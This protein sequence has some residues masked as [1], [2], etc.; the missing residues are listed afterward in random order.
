MS[1][2]LSVT[3]LSTGNFDYINAIEIDT[4][5]LK[6]NNAVITTLSSSSLS[7]LENLF[8]PDGSAAAPSLAFTLDTDLGLFRKAANSLGVS[9]GGAEKLAISSAETLCSSLLRMISGAQVQS[10]TLSLW[11]LGNAVNSG[12]YF[13]PNTGVNKNWI[14][15][16][17]NNNAG[18]SVTDRMLRFYSYSDGGSYSNELQFS[19]NGT[20]KA[21]FGSASEPTFGTYNAYNT[22]MYFPSTSQTAWAHLG[23]NR[24]VLVDNALSHFG[25][26]TSGYRISSDS[27]IQRFWLAKDSDLSTSDFLIYCYDIGGSFTRAFRFHSD[28]S[29]I[30][31]DTGSSAASP[32]YSF[33]GYTSSGMFINTVSNAVAFS[34]GG[35]E[36]FSIGTND[37]ISSNRYQSS[38][39]GA[40]DPQYT[41][42]TDTSSGLRVSS[43]RASLLVGNAFKLSAIASSIELYTNTAVY[44][45]NSYSLG[46]NGGAPSAVVTGR[47]SLGFAAHNFDGD[48]DTGMWSSGANT[49]DLCTGGTNAVRVTS[50]QQ[51]ETPRMHNV[52]PTSSVL[53]I[54]SGT[55]TPTFQN[56]INWTTAPTSPLPGQGPW[57]WT[58]IGRV[59]TV[60]FSWYARPN[61]VSRASFS[62]PLP[63]G[64]GYFTNSIAGSGVNEQ[65]GTINVMPVSVTIFAPSGAFFSIYNP[66]GVPA[67][68]IW[69]T[70][71]FAWVN[72]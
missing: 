17:N 51:I 44:P 7:V 37:N 31:I 4:D 1:E 68:N 52:S 26:G 38:Y 46:V 5:E 55:Y 71:S 54:Q 53:G 40:T 63:F 18:S 56:L 23:K 42:N 49:L 64:G 59:C 34:M 41:V 30:E 20:I 35:S 72:D 33:N 43:G 25:A 67:V 21:A 57:M 15:D 16:M 62:T 8:L 19:R 27:G 12:I 48:N 3:N 9:A 65:Q 6:A 24:L 36:R 2:Y 14:I 45:T 70:G 47:G 50:S 69:W 13:F 10:S 66:G 28:K 61:A 29:Q 39:G 11:T 60:Y 58:K 32:G 22:G